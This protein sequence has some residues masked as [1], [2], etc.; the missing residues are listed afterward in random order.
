MK[1]VNIE[2]FIERAN[3][4]HNNKYDYSLFE[5]QKSIVPNKI[6]CPEHGIFLQSANVHLSGHGCPKCGIIKI[7]NVT[8]HTLKQFIDKSNTI[9]KNK[10]DYSLVEY[11]NTDTKVKIICPTHGKFEQKPDHHLSGHGCPYC[12]GKLTQNMF[13]DKSNVIHDNKYDYSNV[14]YINSITNVII[15][16]PKHGDFFQTPEKHLMGRGCRTCNDSKGELEIRKILKKNKIY[17]I[18][19]HKFI[20]CKDKLCLPFDFYLPVYNLCIE[21]DG[22]QHFKPLKFFG[23]E[24]GLLD[25]IKKDSIKDSFC[26]DTNIKLFRIR[27]DEVISERMEY[28]IKII[29]S[30][31]GK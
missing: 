18:K 31:E 25:N 22:E 17:F 26:K 13:I 3:I 1:K 20:N 6:I 21:Y 29:N 23:G 9:H 11:K 5:Y 14:T 24:D 8:R 27:Y 2:M 16:C 12:R 30:N 4:I 10:Y 19:Q 28:I 7:L 15:I